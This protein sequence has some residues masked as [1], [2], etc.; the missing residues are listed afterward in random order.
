MEKEERERKGCCEKYSGSFDEAL[1][2]AVEERVSKIEESFLVEV[3][4]LI[5][6]RPSLQVT[7]RVQI[8]LC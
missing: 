2:D 8:H 3:T 1:K 6:K 4:E 7:A 5:K